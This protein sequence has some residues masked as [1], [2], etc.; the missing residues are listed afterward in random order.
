MARPLYLQQFFMLF[1]HFLI[2]QSVK[3]LA[4]CCLAFLLVY[5]YNVV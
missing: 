4:L 1:E 5:L 3:L 2:L